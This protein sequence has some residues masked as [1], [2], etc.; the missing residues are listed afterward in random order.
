MIPKK[1]LRFPNRAW[2]VPVLQVRTAIMIGLAIA[3]Y[4][5]M[6]AGSTPNRKSQWL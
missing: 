6:A 1:A 2:H 4:S 5:L 3:R